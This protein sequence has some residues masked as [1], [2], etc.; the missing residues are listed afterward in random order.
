MS[1]R[2]EVEGVTDHLLI[3]SSHFMSFIVWNTSD[4]FKAA[5][6]LLSDVSDVVLVIS[7]I[8]VAES[9]PIH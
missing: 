2:P 8:V 9:F 1:C 5:I 6:A 3:N 7:A 4:P